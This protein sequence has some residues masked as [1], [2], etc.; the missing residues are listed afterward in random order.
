VIN[1]KFLEKITSVRLLIF[2]F[3]GVFTD[4]FV[5]IDNNGVESVKCWR[6]DGLGLS[7]VKELDIPIFI[8]STETN[9]VVAKRAEKLNL[10][11]QQA[12]NDKANAILSICEKAQIEP[13]NTM[14]VGNDIN[15]IPG[16]SVV[17]LPVAVADAYEEV[18]PY[19]MYQT[20]KSGGFGAVREICDL[21]YREKTKYREHGKN[22][23]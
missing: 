22:E 5:Y 20:K 14:F 12:V 3:D 8:V 16:F 4:N 1:N 7:R 15:D 18:L 23:G 21:I 13:S 19:V 10:P 2:D 9:A 6:S 11:L 17:G